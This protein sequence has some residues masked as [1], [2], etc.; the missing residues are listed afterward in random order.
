M[1]IQRVLSTLDLQASLLCAVSRCSASYGRFGIKTISA[2]VMVALGPGRVKTSSSVILRYMNDL[3]PR[4][5]RQPSVMEKIGDRN[6]P[7]R[8][9]RRRLGKVCKVTEIASLMIQVQH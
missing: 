6:G 4:G 1:L 9:C 3:Y 5:L 8:A 7:P 2:P